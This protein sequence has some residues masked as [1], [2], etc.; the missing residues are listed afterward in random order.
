[1][2]RV[3]SPGDYLLSV[4]APVGALN[5]ASETT[6]IGRGLC[7]LRFPDADRRFVWHSLQFASSK[8]NRVAQ[9]STFLAVS[10]SDVEE[11]EIPW[12][13]GENARIAA[14]LDTIDS[15][16]DSSEAVLA[17]LRQVRAGLLHDLLTRGLDADGQL[18]DPDAHPEQFMDSPL[19]RIPRE[20]AVMA[21]GNVCREI[22][23]CK[24][25]TPPYTTEGYPVVRTS[26]VRNGELVTE[27][28]LFTSEEGYK[29]WTQR[30][31]PLPGDLIITREAPVGEACLVPENLRVCLGQR[32]MLY[33]FDKTEASSAFFLNFVLSDTMKRRFEAI[34]DGSTVKHVR[35]QDM[36]EF[37]VPVPTVAEQEAIASKIST[38]DSEIS[39]EKTELAKLR[40]LK[41][42]LMTD[43]LE[44]RVRVPEALQLT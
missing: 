4:R 42:G 23:D 38:V 7:A 13:N 44:G 5:Q 21:I 2:A 43:L 33:V 3:A 32:M 12:R 17:K 41:S 26:N 10:R 37:L 18:R 8:L 16:I 34:S 40:H 20:W 35:I 28:L 24:N 11:L 9:G 36:R 30:R 29:E 14:I 1:M 31:V 22:V 39:A 19:G 27:D 15:L 25:R 6:V